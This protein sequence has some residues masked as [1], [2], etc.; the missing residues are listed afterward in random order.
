MGVGKSTLSKQLAKKLNA[1]Y[2][3][4]DSLL[5]KHGLDKKEHYE[6]TIP[7]KNFIKAD[8]FA[9]P[10]I[11][12]ALKKGK[13][14]ILDGC[15]QHKAQIEHLIENLPS[16]HYVFTLKAP[17]DVCIERD[18]KRKLSY[19]KYAAQAVHTIVSRFDY[20]TIINVETK[21]IDQSVKEILSYL[22]KA[23]DGSQ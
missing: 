22:N 20:G 11:K 7:A 12:N 6:E 15:F 5:E 3:S 14:V 8:E 2:I 17:V 10:E 4:I 21:T 23:G 16:K 19:G 1:E 13:V 9:L 18:S